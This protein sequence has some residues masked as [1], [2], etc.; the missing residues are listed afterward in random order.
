MF[1]SG[2]LRTPKAL[3]VPCRKDRHPASAVSQRKKIEYD[4]HRDDAENDVGD[5]ILRFH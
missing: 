5:E 3:Q 2:R 1:F 4:Q